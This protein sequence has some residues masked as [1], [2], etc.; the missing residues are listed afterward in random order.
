[1]DILLYIFLGILIL[2]LLGLGVYLLLGLYLYRYS[3]SRKSKLKRS[4]ERNSKDYFKDMKLDVDY[5]NK[6]FKTLNV[7]S[8]DNLKLFGYYKDNNG[9]KLVILVHGFGGTHIDMTNYSKLFEEKGYDILAI[10]VR[11]HGKSEGDFVS[12]GLYEQEDLKLWINEVLKIKQSY[13]IVLFGLSLGASTVCLST[14]ELPNNVVLAI[15]DSGFDNAWK[16]VEHI[17]KKTNLKMKIFLKIFYHFMKVTKGV[18]LKK[19]DVTSN[20]RKSK[21]PILFIHGGND[22]FV[23]SSMVYNLY[24]AVPQT[25]KE[26][27]VCKDASHVMSYSIATTKYRRIVKSFLEKYY[28]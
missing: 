2:I 26:L 12:L 6:D 13:K 8:L 17:F 20:L 19:I 22:Y 10:D 4:I 16:E 5:F 18:D 21:I 11:A 28:M 23:P 24:D 3:L 7:T 25:R 27:F 15:E 1:M 9:Q 14:T